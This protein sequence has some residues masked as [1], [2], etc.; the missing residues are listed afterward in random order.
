MLSFFLWLSLGTLLGVV[1][2]YFGLSAIAFLFVLPLLV[3]AVQN[4]RIGSVKVVNL[5]S[6]F[7]WW[8]GAWIALFLSGLVFRIRETD[9]AVSTPL[10]FWAAYRMGLV[11]LVGIILL[12]RLI[13]RQP[14]WLP[15]MTQGSVGFVAGYAALGICSTFWSVYPEWTLY[16]GVEYF[17]DIALVAAIVSS[18]KKLDDWK[19]LFN[20]TW[21]LYGGL[22][23]TILIGLILWPNKT[24]TYGVGL[25]GIQVQGVMPFIASNGVG[26]LGAILSTVALVRLITQEHD[27]QFYITVLGMAF[28]M[29]ILAQTRSALLGFLIAVLLIVVRGKNF[30]FMVLFS[31][32]LMIVLVFGSVGDMIWSY[33]L[34]GQNPELFASLS[35]RTQWW[36]F[37]WDLFIQ[38][39]LTGYGAYAGSRFSALAEAGA[40]TTSSIH[41]TWLE[42]LL[43]V[44]IIGLLLLIA[45]FLTIWKI[46]LRTHTSLSNERV[47]AALTLEAMSVFMVLSVRSWFTSGL[48]WHP[49]LTFLLILGYAE[50]LRRKLAS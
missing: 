44:G 7:Q 14:D 32:G 2:V 38:Q 11:S 17:I 42:A 50:Y 34:R 41:N 31:G 40:E 15:A 22:L 4:F 1:I 12:Y 20:L 8:H 46:F 48:I 21:L 28:G 29:L 47:I 24:I 49:S 5:F 37:G 39:P 9:A 30:G 23:G 43:G 16:K 35:G 6:Q 45:G 10:D 36:Q 25:L 19:L 18:L 26:E 33:I 27:K 3:I 13:M